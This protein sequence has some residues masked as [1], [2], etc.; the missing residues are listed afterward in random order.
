MAI[1]LKNPDAPMSYKQG[2]L[3]RNLG[4]G[5]ARGEDLTQQEASDRIGELMAAKG[6]TDAPDYD[7]LWLSA[8]DAGRI[9]GNGETPT[10]M[11]IAGYDPIMDGVGGFAWVNFKMKSGLARKFGRWLQ[12]EGHGR[13]DDYY[14]GVTIWIGD[15]GQSME[16]KAAHAQAM[17][18]V[19]QEIGIDAYAASR[20]D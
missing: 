1:T 5:D 20:M 19:F 15:Y 11:D 3:I 2:I 9:A 13:K 6:K 17:A 8:V 4:G 18:K 7:G 10:P 16:R 14:G 12:D